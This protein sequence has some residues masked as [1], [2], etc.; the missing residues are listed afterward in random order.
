MGALWI[1]APLFLVVGVVVAV[2][3]AMRSQRKNR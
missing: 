1:L 2:V 3:G